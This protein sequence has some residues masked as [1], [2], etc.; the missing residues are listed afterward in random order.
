MFQTQDEQEEEPKNLGEMFSNFATDS[1]A[2]SAALG[3]LR[4]LGLFVGCIV[5]YRFYGDQFAI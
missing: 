2:R 5:L 1:A 3:H 4:N